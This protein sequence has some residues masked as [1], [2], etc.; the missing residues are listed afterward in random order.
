MSRVLLVVPPFHLPSWPAISVS[1]LKAVL[2]QESIPC[3][4]LYL[5]IRFAEFVGP[6]FYAAVGEHEPNYSALVGEWIFAGDLFGDCAPHPQRYVDEVLRGKFDWLYEQSFVEYVQQIRQRV[7]VFLDRLMTDVSWDEYAV[8]GITSAFQQNCAAL[9]VLKRLKRLHPEIT[10]VMGGANCEGSMGFAIRDLF[11]FVDYI[12]L[13]EGEQVFPQLVHGLFAGEVP[14]RVPGMLDRFEPSSKR[15]LN[16]GAPLVAR[17][18]L[19]TVTPSDADG[20]CESRAAPMVLNL[21]SLPYPDFDDYFKQLKTSP[22]GVTIDPSLPFETSRGCWWG[23]KHHCT[24]CG[25][26][27]ERM[28]FRSKSGDRA[29]AEMNYLVER[30]GV[31]TLFVIDTILD[32]NYFDTFLNELSTRPRPPKLFYETK[33]NLTRPQVQLLARAGVDEIQPGIETLS[34]S[35]L[36][37]MDKGVTALQNVRLLKWCAEAG[38]TPRWYFLFGFPHEDPV[39]YE[40]MATLVPSL[41]HLAPPVAFVQIEIHRFSPNFTESTARGFSNVRPGAMYS[42]VYPFQPRDLTRLAYHFDF[43]YADGRDPEKYTAGLQLAIEHWR[44]TQ[45]SARLYLREREDRVDLIDT[46]PTA[47]RSKTVLSGSAGLAYLALDAGATIQGVHAELAAKLG[48][49]V[50]RVSRIEDWLER[51]VDER[52]AMREGSRYLS[53]AVKS[54]ERQT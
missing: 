37:L 15:G 43:D 32:M 23:E 51:W 6:A 14:V 11:P 42:Y 7:P 16:L 46:R 26:N 13:G 18:S 50:P 33:A 9:A 20:D 2:A 44:E 12:C 3:D 45:S 34:T 22:L 29:T 30:Y 40:L 19:V 1:L 49:K 28:T 36:R 41:T 47:T 10:T 39:E 17:H 25:L 53:L 21:D 35:I 48:N 54:P 27:G 24:F 52:L 4:V 38:I 8:V 5:N 31:N